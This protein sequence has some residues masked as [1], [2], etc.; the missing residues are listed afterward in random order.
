MSAVLKVKA[1]VFAAAFSCVLASNTAAQQ[2]DQNPSRDANA[3]R[4][5]LGQIDRPQTEQSDRAIT[6]ENRRTTANYGQRSDQSAGNQDQ[7]ITR[8]VASCLTAKNEAEVEIGKL[9][10]QQAQNPEVKQFAQQMVQDHQKLVQQ[11][12]QLVAAPAGDRS[13]RTGTSPSLDAAI[14]SDTQRQASDTT[15]L[16]GSSGAG[17]PDSADRANRSLTSTDDSDGAIQQLI[18][19]E[20]QITQRCTDALREELQAKQ[21]AEFDKCYVGAQVGGHMQMLAALEVIGQQGPERLQQIAQQAQP[22]VQKHLDHA[23]TLMKQ[24]ESGRP[25]SSQAERQSPQ[26]QR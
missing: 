14:Q 26:T 19:M 1:G 16:P 24:L 10:Q 9:A 5:S 22:V 2:I 4:P 8:F 13:S 20:R 3:D 7:G 17:Q 21:G 11:L 23:K 25:A 12:Q 15:R 6:P 18:E